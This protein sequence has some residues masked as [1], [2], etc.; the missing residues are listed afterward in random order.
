MQ[1]RTFLGLLGA[2][3]AVAPVSALA[4]QS[5][6]VRR[7]GALTTASKD[8]SEIKARMEAFLRELDR[9]GWRE[10]R[11][12]RIELRES[13]GDPGTTRQFA[14]ELVGLKLDVI[15]GMGSLPVASLLEVARTAHCVRARR[16]SGWGR[17]G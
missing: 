10:G 1:R 2:A 7:I 9:L 5:N 12:M 6:Q 4:Q 15:L 14:R 3:V 8:D 16:R 11:N 17:P 13:A